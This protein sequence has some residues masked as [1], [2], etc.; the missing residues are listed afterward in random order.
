MS[1]LPILLDTHAFHWLA[2]G[3]ERLPVAHRQ[4]A[5]DAPLFVSSVVAWELAIHAR[6]GRLT[7]TPNV[8]DWF[9]QTIVLLPATVVP[10]TADMA[11]RAETLPD[12]HG[13]PADK[14]HV[15]TALL[16]GYRLMTVDGKIRLWA[17]KGGGKALRLKLA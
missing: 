4:A 1:G 9:R 15:A 17:T 7:F 2:T 12:F 5:A 6:K 11:F 10:L 14:F 3:D 13:D 16:L 8:A